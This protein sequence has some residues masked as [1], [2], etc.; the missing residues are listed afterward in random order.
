MSDATDDI[1]PSLW[2][3][4][5]S[6]DAEPTK[7]DKMATRGTLD[8]SEL[9]ADL[10]ASR[11]AA[12]RLHVRLEQHLGTVDLIVTDNRRRMLSSK[13]RRQ[14]QEIRI[15]HMFAGCDDEIV[16]AVADLAGGRK[17]GRETIQEYIQDNRDAI[18]FEPEDDELEARGAHFNLTTILG[19]VLAM[20]DQTDAA[21]G[22]LD[23]LG[24]LHITWGRR[25]RGTKSIRFGS[26][27]FDRKLIR[28]HPALDREFV[29]R[30]FVQFI[31]YHEIL[32]AIFPPKQGNG[33]RQ[34]HPPE[35]R[36]MER[37]FPKYEQA[38]KWESANLSRIL[39]HK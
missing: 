12:H 38:M 7:L 26:Y 1:Q 29:P 32:H 18:R 37:R 27:D 4:T 14:R 3:W 16:A 17:G 15:H 9:P 39:S 23:E 2:E 10:R 13:R 6:P 35:F 19:E 5:G 30:H 24:E 34:V 25:G 11:K 21:Q 36:A 28:I 8:L 22:T 33:R 20:L 31:V